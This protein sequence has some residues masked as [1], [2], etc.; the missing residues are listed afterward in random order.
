MLMACVVVFCTTYALILPAITMEGQQRQIPEHTHTDECYTLKTTAARQVLHCSYESLGVHQHTED[1]YDDDGNLIC[2]QEDFVAHTHDETCYDANGTLV[3]ELPEIKPHTHDES[4]YTLPQ[5]HVHDESCY[6]RVRGELICTES[7]EAVE[8]EMS[9]LVCEKPEDENHT[10]GEGCYEKA[11]AAQP[12]VHT[13]ECYAWENVQVCDKST[14]PDPNARP[15][16]TCEEPEIIPHT[17]TEECYDKDGN[18]VCGEV[19]LLVHQHTASCFETLEEPLDTTALACTLPENENHTHT[20][21]C[22]GRWELTCGLEEHTHSLAC[23]ADP[24]ADVETAENWEATFASAMGSGDWRKD[25]AAIAKTQLGYTESKENYVV[26]EDGETVK[27]YTR[28]G[29]WFGQPYEDWN[30][31]FASFCLNYA[32]AEITGQTCQDLITALGEYYVNPAEHAPQAGEPVFLDMDGDGAADQVGILTEIAEEAAETG[33]GEAAAV[34]RTLTVIS[35]D[36]AGEMGDAV[37]EERYSE[38]SVVGYGA[39]PKAAQPFTL[40]AQTEGGITVTV[41]G[42]DS[43]L[44][45]PAEEI[46]LTVKEQTDPTARA[47]QEKAFEE[48]GVQPEVSV[49]LDITLWHGE[50]EIEP[51][52][53]VTVT[54]GGLNGEGAFPKVYH[55]DTEKESVTDM[56]AK[57]D[58]EGNAVI[59]TDHFST[60]SV[61]RAAQPTGTAIY[62]NC[63]PYLGTVSDPGTNTYYLADN[64]EWGSEI[65]ITGNVT[66]NLNGHSIKFKQDGNNIGSFRISSGGSL[67]IIDKVDPEESDAKEI[68]FETGKTATITNTS[69]NIDGG[70][71]SGSSVSMTYYVTTSAPNSVTGNTTTTEH[72]MQHDMSYKDAGVIYGQDAGDNVIVVSGGLLQ[73]EGGI[74]NGGDRKHAVVLDSNGNNRATLQNG[75][76]YGSKNKGDD[77]CGVY[78]SEGTFSITGGYIIGGNHNE[79]GGVYSSGSIEMSGGVIAANSAASG[80]GVFMNGGSLTMNGGIISGNTAS[81]NGGDNGGGIFAQS[82]ANISIHDGYI[83][84][85]S[86][87]IYCGK[88]GDGCHGGGGIA[89]YGG[90]LNI[91]GG[92]ITGNYSAEAG[93][94]LYVG[95]WDNGTTFTMSGGTVASNC[96]GKQKGTIPDTEDK[97]YGPGSEGGGIRIS[98]ESHAVINASAGNK[99]YITNNKMYSTFDWGGGG[100]FVQEGGTL[101]I[102]NVLITENSADG[103]GGGVGACPTGKNLIVSDMGGAIYDNTARGEHMSGGGHDKNADSTLAKDKFGSY[104]P[105]DYFCVRN[106]DGANE[107]ISLVTGEMKGG[108]AANWSGYCDNDWIT[109]DKSGH[110]AAK[111]LFGLTADPEQS[112]KDKA[113]AAAE[114]IITG[115]YSQNHG[116][117]IMTNGELIIGKTD[118][119]ETTAALKLS[120]TKAMT[121]GN[122]SESPAGFIFELVEKNE[123]GDDIVVGEATSDANGKFTISTNKQYN[124]A[125]TYTYT[126][127]ER[128]GN[129]TDVTYDTAEYKITVKIVKNETVLLGVHFI[130]YE[131]DSVSISKSQ[132]ASDHP[133]TF[134]FYCKK[135]EGHSNWG[136][137]YLY[138]WYGNTIKLTGEWPGTAMT[139]CGD[140]WYC[141]EIDNSN[142]PSEGT[143]NYILSNNGGNQTGD[144]S[145]VASAG[146]EIWVNTEGKPQG[147]VRFTQTANPDG[148]VSVVMIGT[149]F[150]NEVLPPLQ[151]QLVKTDANDSTTKLRDAKFLLKTAN[152]ESQGTEQTSDDDG[153]VTFSISRNTNYWL[154]ETKAPAQH[155]ARGPWIIEVDQDGTA[156]LFDAVETNGTL[157]K[158]DAG[159]AGEALN[160]TDNTT[161][162]TLSTEI[163]NQPTTY[164]L[165]AT[166]GTGTTM[167]TL[168]GLLMTLLAAGLLV[169]NKKSRR[170]ALRFSKLRMRFPQKR[171]SERKYQMKTAKKLASLLLALVMVLSLATTA[172]AAGT[173]SITV[174]NPIAGQTYTAY[175]IFDVVYDTDG[176]YSYT[177]D[178]S[179]EWFD[180]V[181]TYATEANG[182]TLTQVNGSTTYNA[183]TTSAFSAPDF[184]AALKTNISGKTG[185]IQLTVTDGKATATG[186]DLGYYFVTSSTGALCNLTTTNPTATI[187]DKNDMPFNKADDKVSADVGETVNYTITG[188]VPDYTGFDT[189]TY[190]ITDTMSDGL[191]FKKDVKVTVGGTDVTS[192]CTVIYD[193]DNNANKFTVSIPVKS[194]TIGAEIKV[195]YSAVVNENAVAKIG[196]NSATLTYSNNPTSNEVTTTQPSTET[197]YSSKIV[198]DKYETSKETTKLAG[199]TFVL[200]KAGTTEGSKLYYMYTAATDTAA[201]KVEWVENKNEATPKT[202]DNKGA[203]SFDGLADGTYYLE[204][205]EAPAGYN[206]LTQPVEVT[207]NGGTTETQLSVTAKVANNTGTLLPSTGGMGTTLFYVLGSI[208]AIGAVV[209]LVTKKRMSASN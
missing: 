118:K 83:T 176:H 94:G 77:G 91:S 78:V 67:T 150:T 175:K 18:L 48:D 157:V 56:A 207:V 158:K 42:E 57:S 26:A 156:K 112:A 74:I 121:G 69:F 100:V 130:S 183:V 19:E 198:I 50:E 132:V 185:G 195:T 154:W 109:I 68:P 151:L 108:D 15:V 201:A 147:N 169:Y 17:H 61:S 152:S 129:R 72:L 117:G 98:K 39:V 76:I 32:G 128:K 75:V 122:G 29:A 159:A 192:A 163:P 187:H 193:V 3:C 177:I 136:A 93:G 43:S 86:K 95:H 30:A 110:A 208:L 64:V 146:G 189:Y 5:P 101:N 87:G 143:L 166:G 13:D 52:G 92:Y 115:N 97:E 27:G 79:G 4:C 120:G 188:K 171:I 55:I 20:E 148:T 178:S 111:Y 174:D 34:K 145:T 170:G 33:E 47:L 123:N 153:I 6:E 203:A 41:S 142:L 85:N 204:E 182:L 106:S 51:I 46:T 181:K 209:L 186:L 103:Y 28:Y 155:I 66:L 194:Y 124:E 59:N 89:I 179:S 104:V 70:G 102:Q 161:V 105:K 37:R 45:Y 73:I 54:F 196:K 44:P 144:L 11:P 60:Y 127:R 140:G 99:V 113:E 119:V 63:T 200:Y 49:L 133:N 22:Y 21:R 7:T 58:E 71:T 197:V 206:K 126:L 202:T 165:P 62:F 9:V 14:E 135:A 31:L 38:A 164:E 125:G 172:F 10:H 81:R 107:Y 80:G 139:D 173:G 36:L 65:N 35:G 191:T 116:G 53:T 96:A 149:T 184:A 160:R 114:V 134:K 16:L 162:I 168:G 137:P 25:A 167:Y 23:Y 199:A 131:V 82:S 2:G 8:E 138:S 90:T 190:L 12:H 88:E 40:T 205:T 180:T 1:C 24:Q 141:I 84:N